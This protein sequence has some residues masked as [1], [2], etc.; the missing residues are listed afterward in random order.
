MIVVF[1]DDATVY[2]PTLTVYGTIWNWL[3]VFE[4]LRARIKP[5]AIHDLGRT[6]PYYTLAYPLSQVDYTLGEV[7]KGDYNL[8][9]KVE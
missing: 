1:D 4:R 3:S 5:P 7:K 6:K 9:R 8:G 2:M